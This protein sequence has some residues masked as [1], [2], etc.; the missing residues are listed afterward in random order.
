MHLPSTDGTGSL[1]G[2]LSAAGGRTGRREDS[3]SVG[4]GIPVDLLWGGADRTA[5]GEACGW[6]LWDTGWCYATGRWPEGK[7]GRRLVVQGQRHRLLG[8]G[9]DTEEMRRGGTGGQ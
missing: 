9:Q 5:D 2:P 7:T 8:R 1:G 6:L 3:C 4:G